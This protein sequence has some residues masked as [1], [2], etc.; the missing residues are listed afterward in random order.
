MPMMGAGLK[1]DVMAVERDGEPLRLGVVL[2][3]A[4]T[5]G[6]AQFPARFLPMDA[7]TGR[8]IEGV[9]SCEVDAPIDDI[10]I[11]RLEAYVHRVGMDKAFFEG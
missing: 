4:T 2:V 8:L 3:P 1:A 9:V 5:A 11:V 6:P 7:E 10:V